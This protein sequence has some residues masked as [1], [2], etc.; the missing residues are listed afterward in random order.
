MSL[1]GPYYKA[2]MYHIQYGQ[3][4]SS[5]LTDCKDGKL[6]ILE[7][8]IAFHLIVARRNKFEIPDRLPKRLLI[9]GS[10]QWTQRNL[11]D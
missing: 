4:R 3:L 11:S 10:N 1:Y 9:S 6:S 7:F 5:E 8:M 2:R